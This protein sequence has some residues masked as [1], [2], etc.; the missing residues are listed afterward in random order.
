MLICTC[1]GCGEFHVRKCLV[2]CEPSSDCD[3]VGAE[4]LK[5]SELHWG[6]HGSY[7]MGS[8]VCI[9]GT[10]YLAT[11][12]D[13]CQ[14]YCEI[15]HWCRWTEFRLSPGDDDWC[16]IGWWYWDDYTYNSCN[17][18]M[19]DANSLITSPYLSLWPALVLLPHYESAERETL[20]EYYTHQTGCWLIWCGKFQLHL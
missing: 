3:S 19:E 4:F 17:V 10:E 6:G 2:W 14:W 1:T 8:A 11:S 12:S 5:T 20:L 9:W 7:C 16:D 15:Q 18:N 13:L